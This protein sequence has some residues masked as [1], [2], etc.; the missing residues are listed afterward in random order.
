M[1][2]I[3]NVKRF[4]ILFIFFFVQ[5][6]PEKMYSL[7]LK[8][9]RKYIKKTIQNVLLYCYLTPKENSYNYGSTGCK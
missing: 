7:R 4:R 8:Y 5:R 3:E 1:Y 9:R 2:Y 6:K